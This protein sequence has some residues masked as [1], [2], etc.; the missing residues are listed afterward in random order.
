M[1]KQG[2]DLTMILWGENSLKLYKAGEA[3]ILSLFIDFSVSRIFAIT[4]SLP[5]NKQKGPLS[6]STSLL[7]VANEIGQVATE[8]ESLAAA[9]S[10]FLR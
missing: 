3:R 5:L 10:A 4:F 2:K 6:R 1:N 9:I 8:V 7:V